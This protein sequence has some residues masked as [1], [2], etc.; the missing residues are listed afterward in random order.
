MI[1][2]DSV[3]STPRGTACKNTPFATDDQTILSEVRA[4]GGASEVA[5]TIP[6]LI[7]LPIAAATAAPKSRT[8]RSSRCWREHHGEDSS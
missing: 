5:I 3:L 6:Q 1:Q 4:I 2:A 8:L 7:P